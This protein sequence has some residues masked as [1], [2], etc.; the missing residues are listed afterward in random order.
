M[1]LEAVERGWVPDAL[2]RRGIRRLLRD[3]LDSEYGQ[4]GLAVPS[5]DSQRAHHADNPRLS[6]DAQIAAGQQALADALSQGP[7]VVHATDAN[8]QHYEVPAEFFRLVLGQQLKYSCGYWPR[9][10]MSLDEA[11]TAMLELTVQRAGVRDGMELL[12]LGCGWGSLTL[13][14]AEHFP[15]SRVTAVSNSH[16][17][18][19]F[20]QQQCQL[21]QLTN[22]QVITSNIAE[23]SADARSFDRVLSVEMFEHVRN[24]RQ[25]MQHVSKWLKEDGQLFV[26]IFCHRELTYL[27]DAEGEENWMGRNFFSGGMM[28]SANWLEHQATNLAL[29][30]QW[31]VDG[32]HYQRTCEAWLRNLNARRP[33]VKRVLANELSP[34]E[35]ARQI[36][37]WRMFFMACAELFGY[38]NGQ[39]WYVGH[40][41]FRR[42]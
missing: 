34:P 29:Q 14:L 26:H 16:G 20:I 2:V 19:R 40:Y 9:P 4:L 5:D 27:F 7:M 3:R 30:R 32:T 11:E 10:E 31:K 15:N 21:R 13:W 17:Q 23:F 33:A 36:Q 25:L 18:R 12:E 22:V 1:L 35:V 39:E 6:R 41:L 8:T 24:H 38:R 42:I 37:R 28:P